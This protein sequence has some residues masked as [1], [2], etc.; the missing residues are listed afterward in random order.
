MVANEYMRNMEIIFKKI[1]EY[2]KIVNDN[3]VN[4][5]LKYCAT[6]KHSTSRVIFKK[7]KNIKENNNK[8]LKKRNNVGSMKKDI[9]SPNPISMSNTTRKRTNTIHN[10]FSKGSI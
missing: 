4:S 3:S 10:P 2:I 7:D 8:T 9:K 5:D 6:M 1:E